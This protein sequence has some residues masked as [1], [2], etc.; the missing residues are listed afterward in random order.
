MH[1]WRVVFFMGKQF[2]SKPPLSVPDQIKL[3]KTRGLQISD[4]NRANRYLQSISY[5]HLSGYMYPFLTDKKQHQYKPGSRF[6]DIINLYRFDRELRIL[7]FFY[8]RKN[9]TCNSCT[10]FKSFCHQ[11]KRPILVHRCKIFFF[12]GRAHFF[13]K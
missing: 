2:Y 12:I 9:R 10:D 5:Y 6:D 4:E 11:Y 13:F 3:L 7:I 8:Y 1:T